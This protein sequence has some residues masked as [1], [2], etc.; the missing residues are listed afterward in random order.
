MQFDKNAIIGFVLLALLFLGFFYFTRQG[1]L[2]AE[3][4]Q[5]HIQDSLALI[6]PKADSAT[7]SR[8][9]A[10]SDS[11]NRIRSAGEFPTAAIGSEK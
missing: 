9:K 1:Q 10:G 5:K 7:L 2:E 8:E 3:K 11:L 6:Q 4:K